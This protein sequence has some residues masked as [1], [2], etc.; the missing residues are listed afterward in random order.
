MY[1]PT[2]LVK[3]KYL[4]VQKVWFLGKRSIGHIQDMYTNWGTKIDFIIFHISHLAK[5]FMSIR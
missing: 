3:N 5:T 4:Y 2:L 1:W